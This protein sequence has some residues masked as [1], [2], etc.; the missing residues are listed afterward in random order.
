MIVGVLRVELAVPEA[1]SLKAKR[2]VIKSLKD[3]LSHRHNVSV[4]EVESLDSHQRAVLGLAMVA[5]DSRFVRSCL[6]K[7]VDELR[8]ARAA[9]LVDYDVEIMSGPWGD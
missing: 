6:D 1:T 9:I 7:I 5:N 8:V 4:A 2:S 3:R